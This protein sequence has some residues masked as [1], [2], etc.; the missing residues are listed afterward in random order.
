MGGE[1]A[2][3]QVNGGYAKIEGGKPAKAMSMIT[4]KSTD[5]YSPSQKSD[6]KLLKSLS[7][8]LK[9]GHPTT[10]ST[11]DVG[12]SRKKK[13]GWNDLADKLNVY[14]NHA[15][16]LKEVKDGSI[17]LYN[18]WGKDHPLPMSPGEFKQLYV[19]VSINQA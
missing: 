13:S 19:R 16:A 10:A 7:S 4:G 3:A 17:V 14:S 11:P 12:G 1:K 5:T 9:A 15:Y 2:W 8:A 6:D 18:P